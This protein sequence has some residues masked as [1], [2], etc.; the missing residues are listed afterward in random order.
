MDIAG[1]GPELAAGNSSS[2]GCY[3][4]REEADLDDASSS[5][6]HGSHDSHASKGL[7]SNNAVGQNSSSQ[8]AAGGMTTKDLT[9]SSQNKAHS[10]AIRGDAAMLDTAYGGS[11]VNLVRKL[12]ML[13]QERKL[14]DLIDDKNMTAIPTSDVYDS[15]QKYNNSDIYVDPLLFKY[16]IPEHVRQAAL[17]VP[18]LP[19]SANT[20]AGA[21]KVLEKVD[22]AKLNRVV[23][24][25]DDAPSVANAVADSSST[26]ASVVGGDASTVVA[27]A[28]TSTAVAATSKLPDVH[29][30]LQ[31]PLLVII[32]HGKTEHNKLGLF[33]GWEDASL[34]PEGRVEARIAG[35]LLRKHGV[36]VYYLFSLIC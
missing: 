10:T 19:H 31:K 11:D 18:K 21:A 27:A 34:S 23:Y 14:F 33:T 32:R 13:D 36:K 24:F 30:L 7:G 22:V 25:A 15:Y 35:K 29:P 9:A 2:L 17:M 28:D 16:G 26:S 20:S 6:S 5:T 4:A 8:E 3:S 12:I 1:A